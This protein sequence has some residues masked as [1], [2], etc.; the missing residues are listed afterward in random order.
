MTSVEGKELG[1]GVG[2]DGDE[3]ALEEAGVGLLRLRQRGR[4]ALEEK[5]ER[6]GHVCGNRSERDAESSE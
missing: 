6:G 1:S 4:R 5:V 3:A 2:V